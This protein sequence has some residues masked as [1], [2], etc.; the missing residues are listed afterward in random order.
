[1]SE[2]AA[3]PFCHLPQETIIR[4]TGNNPTIRAAFLQEVRNEAR[5]RLPGPCWEPEKV[6]DPKL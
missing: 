2:E 6:G 5:R 1:M 4:Q 3:C